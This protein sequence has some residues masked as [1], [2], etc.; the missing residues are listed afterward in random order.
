MYASHAAVLPSITFEFY[1]FPFKQH[2]LLYA[3]FVTQYASAPSPIQIQILFWKIKY[4]MLLKTISSGQCLS[5][6]DMPPGQPPPADHS[7]QSSERTQGILGSQ[8]KIGGKPISEVDLCPC[9]P[10]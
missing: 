6:V 8:R 2:G 4:F 7:L 3:F 9:N 5:S 10:D 1:F